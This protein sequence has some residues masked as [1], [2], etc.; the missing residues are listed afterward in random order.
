MKPHWNVAFF[1]APLGLQMNPG[2]RPCPSCDPRDLT[3]DD[4]WAL[5]ANIFNQYLMDELN[6]LSRSA[7]RAYVALSLR[8]SG[9]W[10]ALW[11]DR[12]RDEKSQLEKSMSSLTSQHDTYLRELHKLYFSLKQV[13]K[14]LSPIKFPGFA[15]S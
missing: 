13:K 2:Y 6:N 1:P 11:T 7:R 10:E 5:F 8:E 4:D 12:V 15:G 9:C 3:F 14:F